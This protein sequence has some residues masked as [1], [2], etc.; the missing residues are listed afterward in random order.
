MF[1]SILIWIEIHMKS[2]IVIG[3]LLSTIFLN[4]GS[5]AVAKVKEHKKA[6]RRVIDST[7]MEPAMGW[8]KLKDLFLINIDDYHNET[9]YPGQPTVG[10]AKK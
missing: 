3:I 1:L 6:N 2:S 9:V 7:S 4:F 10:I 5:L 8:K